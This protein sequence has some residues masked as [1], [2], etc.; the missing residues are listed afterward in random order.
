MIRTVLVLLALVLA[1]PAL[2]QDKTGLPHQYRSGE[3]VTVAPDTAYIL[4]RASL[5]YGFR[6]ARIEGEVA[7]DVDRADFVDVAGWRPVEKGEPGTYLIAVR[8]GTYWLYGEKTKD[9][10]EGPFLNCLCMGTLRF[11]AR[12][13]TITD[14]G[15][16]RNLARETRDGK[17]PDARGETRVLLGNR[18]I[19]AILIEPA[20]GGEPVP[21]M[22]AG[23]PRVAAA[24]RAA[25]RLPN[26]DGTMIDRVSTMSGVI[27]YDR[28]RIIDVPTGRVLR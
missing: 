13:G 6:F 16:I 18:D 1:T 22:L 2:A 3:A 12:A 10:L 11:E 20:T 17:R 21:A 27:A 25:G 24:Y 5:I 23:L 15:R 19:R 4:F 8:P 14:L 7:D 9:Y 26:V 28:D